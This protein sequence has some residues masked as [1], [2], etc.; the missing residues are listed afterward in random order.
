MLT[1]ETIA[2]ATSIVRRF[3]AATAMAV[4]CACSSTAPGVS[5]AP[6]DP[7]S[8]EY[9]ETRRLVAL[10]NDAARR[11][12][13]DGEAAF[14]EFRVPGGRWREAEM[15]VFVLDTEGNM[16]VHPDPALEGT[17]T[18]DLKDVN[19][20]PIVRGLIHA[21]T[22]SPGKPGGW[23]HY[24][25]PVPG[26]L[27]PRW[28]GS[29][30]RLATAPS[31][32][33]FVTGSGVYNDRMERA[34][35]VD[36]VEAAAGQVEQIG[37]AAFPLFR[38]PAGPFVAKDA[39]VFVLDPNGVELV[40]PA[41]PNLEGRNLLDV[42]DTQGKPLVR[43][44]LGVAE[45]QGSGW[46]D[47]MWPKPGESV[48]TRKSTYVRKADVGG[49]R[50]LVGAGVYLADAP[51][52]APDGAK[53]TAPALIAFVR[54]AA[55]VFEQRGE[56]AFAEFRRKGSKWFQGDTYVFVWTAEGTR[57]FNAPNPAMEGLD[58]I[59]VKDAHG[60]PY[61]R[62]F[63]D[64]AASQSGE[65]WVHYMFH[66]PGGIFPRWKSS[67]LKRVASPS[68]KQHL[69]GCG[70]YEMQ[71]DR[72]FIVDLVDRAAA[73]V[74]E[75]G[76][77]AFAELRDRRGPFVFMDTYVFV[78]TPDGVELV[79]PAQPSLEGKNLLD[80]RDADGKAMVREYTAAALKDG[81]AWVEYRWH[82]PGHD[83]ASRKTTYVRLVRSGPDA[84]VVGS[85][86]YVDD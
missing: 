34:F 24:E 77:R 19:G 67:F 86:F 66:E 14:P 5:P 6:S 62:M 53:M 10:V 9:D 17:A 72:T 12:E 20:R 75:R 29:Y 38:D 69:V 42:K 55:A 3:V 13:T 18:P 49:R 61:G 70:I 68:G 21:A 35:V 40:N 64:V 48:S 44:M 85:G 1:H 59:D 8:Y 16:L 83:A 56:A 81:A 54:E 2:R 33:R 37:D 74:A 82:R 28:K 27:L 73:L 51:K 31:G 4:L 65:G 46:V 22:A 25:W 15:Y 7:T 36:M 60:R 32:R 78:D 47:Y 30:V 41:F 80:V 58:A 71:M 84:Y 45:T 57:V 76:T 63:R 50:L 26:G 11:I 52:S 23:Y 79:N 43:E 39:Y